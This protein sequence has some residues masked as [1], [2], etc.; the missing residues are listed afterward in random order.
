MGTCQHGD[1]FFSDPPYSVQN[2]YFLREKAFV[3]STKPDDSSQPDIK[4][5]GDEDLNDNDDYDDDDYTDLI[6]NAR[7]SL[8]LKRLREDESD[9]MRLARILKRLLDAVQ[10][11][12]E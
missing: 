10:D 12:T 8:P 6:I 7:K 11:R 4:K 9:K 5:E 1:I 3:V 2:A